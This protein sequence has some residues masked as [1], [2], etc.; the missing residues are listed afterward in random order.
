[1]IDWSESLAENQESKTVVDLNSDD[2]LIEI[3]KI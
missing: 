1:M 2:W 3:D